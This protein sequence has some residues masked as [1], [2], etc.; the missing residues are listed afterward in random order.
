[1]R[2]EKVFKDRRKKGLKWVGGIFTIIVGLSLYE[3]ETAMGIIFVLVG[4]FIL[5][6]VQNIIDK[7]VDITSP[8]KYLIILGGFALAIWVG[9]NN[10]INEGKQADK[11]VKQSLTAIST[12]NFDKANKLLV[13]A[14]D[15]Y[16]GSDN[17][18]NEIKKM[19]ENINS[20]SYIKKSLSGLSEQEFKK[21]KNGTLKVSILSNKTLNKVLLAKMQE[22]SSLRA[23]YLEE[24]EQRREQARIAARKQKTEDQF[25]AWDGSHRKLEV[26][27][28]RN[29][30]DP[31]S[32]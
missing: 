20:R 2:N 15:L 18:A 7:K 22:Q 16:R 5:P 24:A 28:K 25:S 13:E 14:G 17:K 19:L 27:I 32:Y 23:E 30:H 1:M 4:V 31:D 21:L 10:K 26:Y 11:I 8:A 29:M 3:T 9:Y 6:I 12:N